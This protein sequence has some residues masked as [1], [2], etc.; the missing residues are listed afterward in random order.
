[1]G[2]DDLAFF[3]V[4]AGSESLT[5]AARELS[6]SLPVVSRRLAALEQRL[7]VRLVHRGARRMS[8]TPEGR[9]YAGRAA[10]IL[11]QV[12]ELDE[13]VADGAGH[14]RGAVTVLSTPG[15]GRAHI[16]PL[17]GDFV[18]QHPGVRAQL[19]VSSLP[20][21]PQ[22]RG[23]DVAIRVG[24]APDSSLK[25]RRL[26]P[27]RRVP[28]ASPAYLARRGTPATL[29]DLADHDCIALRENEAT[30]PAWAFGERGARTVAVG[31]HLSSNDGDV[32]TGWALDGRGI[33]M[34]SEWQVRE[35]LASGALVRVLPE[36]ATPR[37]DVYALFDA[38]RH[39]PRRVV[40]LIDLL[41]ERL[42][43]RL[44]R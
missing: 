33:I 14:L 8:L 6:S 13:Q 21:Q 26:A 29:A 42:P 35:H 17:L 10:A 16:A 43:R 18:A 36:V 38:E 34:R 11:D 15:I 12:H 39:V 19:Q 28:C 4:V 40:A 1:M 37:A 20:L 9:L 22:R 30:S 24:S 44:G 32:V 7:G 3:R 41:A 5:A 2:V 25:M 27:G 23:F 31:A